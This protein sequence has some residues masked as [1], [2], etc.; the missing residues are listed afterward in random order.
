MKSIESRKF[1]SPIKEK[2]DKIL[3]LNAEPI[4]RIHTKNEIISADL[5]LDKIFSSD[6]Y[7]TPGSK[8]EIDEL[9]AAT[10]SNIKN[11]GPINCPN[12]I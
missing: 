10:D 7:A 3:K 6:K 11:N 9:K 12:C 1:L 5:F 8:R 2:S 4:P